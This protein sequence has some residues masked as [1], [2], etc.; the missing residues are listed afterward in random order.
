MFYLS[1]W[2]TGATWG[3]FWPNHRELPRPPFVSGPHP[4]KDRAL[5][6]CW[7]QWAPREVF[8]GYGRWSRQGD[9]PHSGLLL[10]PA[11]HSLLGGGLARLLRLSQEDWADSSDSSYYHRRRMSQALAVWPSAGPRIDWVIWCVAEASLIFPRYWVIKSVDLAGTQSGEGRRH[12][13]ICLTDHTVTTRILAFR[14]SMAAG[15]EMGKGRVWISKKGCHGRFRELHPIFQTVRA[16]YSDWFI[17]VFLNDFF[18]CGTFVGFA[19]LQMCLTA[20]LQ[21][22]RP[23]QWHQIPPPPRQ[24]NQKNENNQQRWQQAREEFWDKGRRGGGA[25]GWQLWQAEKWSTG[26]AFIWAALGLAR[27]NDDNQYFTTIVFYLLV[28]WVRD[29][30]AASFD[31]FHLIACQLCQGLTKDPGFIG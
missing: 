27:M 3:G 13:K 9:P 7:P 15:W 2:R 25:G 16:S 22:R 17:P 4:V 20:N 30:G 19:H 26:L 1:L 11:Q 12:K 5:A 18:L 21:I 29:A 14:W 10:E 28:D 23:R 6:D 24:R 8:W 31:L